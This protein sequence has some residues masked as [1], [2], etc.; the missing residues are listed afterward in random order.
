MDDKVF[1]LKASQRPARG[2]VNS[3][4]GGASKSRR[5]LVSAYGCEPGKGSE[6][7]VG[8]N[9]VLQ[10]AR[11]AELVVLTRS[12]NRESIEAGFP[13]AL[14]HRVHFEY[15][16][17]S[18]SVIALK[19]KEK[20]LYLYYLAW[21]W[22]AYRRA[23]QLVRQERFDYVIALTFGSIWMPT[24]MHRLPLPFIWGPIGGGEAV[25]FS[26]I[27]ALP[28]RA[29]FPQLLRYL[30]MT[31]VRLNPLVMRPIRRAKVILARTG[32]TARLIPVPYANKV[33]VILETA[34][35]DDL[36]HRTTPFKIRTS[37]EALRVIYSG[38][39]VALKNVQAALHA[40]ARAK[41]VGVS[42][43][44][45]IIGNGPERKPLET[46]ARTLGIEREIRFLGTIP[47]TQVIEELQ[48]G[49]IY[50]FPSYKEGGVWSLMEA[51]SVGLPVVCLNTSGMSIIA[52][53]A[54]AIRVKPLSQEQIIDGF[55]QALVALANSPECCRQM[56]ESAQT[57]M[58]K[59]FCWNHKGDFM[60]VLLD[61]LEKHSS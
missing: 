55:A 7:G 51:M 34:I 5:L 1:G 52:D 56:G 29:R 25:P 2:A 42:I 11:S 26:L 57:R 59:H 47:Q 4:A 49:D 40:A 44:L 18:S 61:E 3:C 19:R 12:N 23:R 48:Q 33:K 21:Q 10:L 16:D 41:D 8:W 43:R 31:T 30:L 50:L 13:Q 54:S 38:R 37:G 45:V 39:L 6:Q 28:L 15:Y 60:R 20:G 36:L 14:R 53:E 24:F 27:S 58:Q 32:D 35:S 17:L 22:G 9:W 46:L